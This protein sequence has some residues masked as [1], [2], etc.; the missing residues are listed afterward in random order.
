MND[1]PNYN[2]R[3][4]PVS[5]AHYPLSGPKRGPVYAPLP[6]EPRPRMFKPLTLLVTVSIILLLITLYVLFK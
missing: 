2:G 4:W 3:P 1:Q 5:P 6:T